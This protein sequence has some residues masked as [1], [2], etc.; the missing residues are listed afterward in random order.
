MKVL[1]YLLFWILLIPGRVNAQ[2]VLADATHI[3]DR[4][5]TKQNEP[6]KSRHFQVQG[7]PELT[8]F[9]PSGDIEVVYNPD[10]DGV[11][12]DLYVK[13]SF[14]FWSGS[15]S[16]DRYRVIFRQNGNS[17]TAS[18]ERK[19]TTSGM[20]GSDDV[21]FR[22]VIQSPRKITTN[23]RSMHG[24]VLLDGAAGNQFLQS[25]AG[26][27]KL[28]N[29][30][31][32]ISLVSSAGDVFLEKNSGYVQVKSIAGDV[33][34]DQNHGETRI[35]TVSGNILANKISGS[36]ICATTSGEIDVS[37]D[38][39]RQGVYMETISGNI[40]MAINEQQG[41]DIEAGTHQLDVNQ[42]PGTYITRRSSDRGTTNLKLGEGGIPVSI[43]TISGIV[44]I[45]PKGD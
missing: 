3:S 7:I 23:L 10:I 33:F 36:F 25:D 40:F 35:R 41:F 11:K 29:S 15:P 12:V 45:K 26:A 24:E 31:G 13:Q 43:S 4:P 27:I 44:Q 6:Y 1:L 39:I 5:A 18:V 32:E 16:L 30:E 21:R 38:H 34:I 28:R 37:F 9:T 19:Q 22:F 2:Q 17:I 20:F 8:V 14:S 42:L